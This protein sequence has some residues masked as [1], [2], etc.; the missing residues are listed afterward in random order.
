[1]NLDFKRKKDSNNVGNG[2]RSWQSEAFGDL[3]HLIGKYR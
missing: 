1:M 2:S 3:G